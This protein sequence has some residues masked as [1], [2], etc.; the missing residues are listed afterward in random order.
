MPR[1]TRVKAKRKK[2]LVFR[3]T[4]RKLLTLRR[5]VYRLCRHKHSSS[6]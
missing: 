4:T 2:I 6:R 3:R 1:S 5:S